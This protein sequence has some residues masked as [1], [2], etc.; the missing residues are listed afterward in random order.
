MSQLNAA[1]LAAFSVDVYDAADDLLR[2]L[3]PGFVRLSEMSSGGLQA[4]AYLNQ[5]TGELVIAYQG[6]DELRSV[7]TS[8]SSVTATGDTVFN[9]ALD[10]VAQARAQAEATSGL[11][12][13]D[14]DV[15]LT[16][17]GVG[18]GFAS[19]LS[20]ATGLEA[21]AFNGLRIG[22]LMSAL[23]ERFGTL[24]EDYANRI[25]N[26]VD[27]NEDLYTLPR[28]TAQVGKVVDVQT[29]SLSFFGQL[30]GAFGTDTLGGNVLESVYDWLAMADE[31]RQ[32]AQRLMMALEREFG[33]VDLVDAAGQTIADGSG[34]DAAQTEALI[35]QLNEL[36]QT[37]HADIIQSRP[38]NRMLVDS[39]DFG[40]RQDASDY[41]ESDDL[42]VGATGADAL[43]GGEGSD[44]LFGGDAN[45]ILAGGAGEDYL[46]GGAGSDLYRVDAGGGSDTLRDKEGTN[47]II[48][49]GTPLAPFF[50]ADGQG[51]WK[52][53]DG[54][55]SL[56]RGAATSLAFANGASVSAGG[57]RRGRLRDRPAGGEAGA[58]DGS[59]ERRRRRGRCLRG[60]AGERTDRR[61]GREWMRSTASAATTTSTP[62]TGAIASTATGTA[63]PATTC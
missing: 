35:A 61:Q 20:V 45:D 17:H 62:G 5:A 4:V 3:P 29:S 32:R 52:S 31:D 8:L 43:A 40:E 13:G 15:T 11:V 47:R 1:Q 26:Y 37:S 51:G 28:R 59:I 58:G 6:A 21:V 53:V 30:Q 54:S 56:S 22:G 25:V 60:C 36:M 27:T 10:F 18:G 7:F 38:F 14:G 19:L 33:G 57:V 46:L 49:D 12:L 42:L 23:E 50:I 2:R 9:A 34:A 48:V 55:A 63:V 24:A 41:G 44:V 16:G 39:S